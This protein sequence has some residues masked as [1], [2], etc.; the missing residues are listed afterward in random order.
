MAPR[1]VQRSSRARGAPP[2]ARALRVAKTHALG[3]RAGRS[4]G[5][6]R[7]GAPACS[8]CGAR[9]GS[10]CP[11]R[12]ASIT[13][14]PPRRGGPK[15][16]AP[17]ARQAAVGNGPSRTTGAGRP[18]VRRAA[19]NGVVCPRPQGPRPPPRWPAAAAC[20]APPR[21]PHSILLGPHPRGEPCST[22]RQ[23]PLAYSQCLRPSQRC[24]LLPLALHSALV[25][26]D[27]IR[28]PETG[29]R[30]PGLVLS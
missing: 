17:S 23:D 6:N 21:P 28:H 30:E 29:G 27:L 16:G 18:G 3:W 7:W 2:R 14:A 20:A 25:M 5:R 24:R 10:R 1:D 22:G 26:L 19:P 15:R 4:G 13:P 11:E 12:V 9:S 8:I